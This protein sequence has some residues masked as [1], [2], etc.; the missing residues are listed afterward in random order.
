MLWRRGH[1]AASGLRRR[2]TG[3]LPSRSASDADAQNILDPPV[4]GELSLDIGLGEPPH[5]T[6][7]EPPQEARRAQRYRHRRDG[8]EI[9]CLTVPKDDAQR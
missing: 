4:D 9:E 5:I 1:L 7:Q 2:S 6:A 8:R 3:A